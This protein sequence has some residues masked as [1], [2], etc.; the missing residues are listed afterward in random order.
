[1]MLH[2]GHIGLLP[3]TPIWLKSLVSYGRP[4]SH[5]SFPVVVR[6]CSAR[7]VRLPSRV[8]EVSLTPHRKLLCIAARCF[9]LA[10]AARG[11]AGVRYAH[12]RGHA[13]DPANELADGLAGL[14]A[15]GRSNVGILHFD[16]FSWLSDDALAARWLPHAILSSSRPASAADYQVWCCLLV[17]N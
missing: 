16:I 5:L 1:M 13:G 14:G 7:T 2:V 12:V 3:L 4:W 6:S 11:G 17:L 10:V 8:L 15:A 9:H